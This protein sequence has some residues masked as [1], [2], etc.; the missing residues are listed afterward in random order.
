MSS[1][2]TRTGS[3][4]HSVLPLRRVSS[5]NARR[6]A[7]IT[8]DGRTDCMRTKRSAMAQLVQWEGESQTYDHYVISSQR[9][10]ISLCGNKMPLKTRPARAATTW[11]E[12]GRCLFPFDEPWA[13]HL[14]AAAMLAGV[15]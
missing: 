12:V 3:A 15:K 10:V 5:R 7:F 13:F 6:V 9:S 8:H 1:C 2:E 4:T 11:H 14:V